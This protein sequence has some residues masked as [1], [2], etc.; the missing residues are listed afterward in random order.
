MKKWIVVALVVV[1]T[2]GAVKAGLARSKIIDLIFED[3]KQRIYVAEIKM[4]DGEVFS[5]ETTETDFDDVEFEGPIKLE[6]EDGTYYLNS[7]QVVY[8]RHGAGTESQ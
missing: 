5:F 8:I 7:A 4:T 2:A 6:K 1:F 3:D